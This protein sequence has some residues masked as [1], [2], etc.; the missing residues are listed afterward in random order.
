MKM[1]K[2]IVPHNF[3]VTRQLREKLLQQKAQLIWFTGLSGS[4]KSTIANAFELSLSK[5]SYKTYLLDGDNIRAGINSN[6]SFSKVDRKENIRRIAEVAKLLLDAGIIVIAA[7][8]SPYEKDRQMVKSLV[9]AD[10]F[11]EI[12]INT[13]LSVCEQRDTKGF[14]KLA[15][16][17]KIDNFTGINAPYEEPRNADLNLDTSKYSINEAILLLEKMIFPKIESTK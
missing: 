11:N 4:G 14:Y 17:G 3:V 8:V 10:N 13:P 1:E 12:Y 5:K 2:N 9:G 6:L 16:E 15:R 7:F